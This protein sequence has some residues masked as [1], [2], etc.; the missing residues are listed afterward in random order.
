M[1]EKDRYSPRGT[2]D[3]REKVLLTKQQI[4]KEFFE[5]GSFVDLKVSDSESR[6]TL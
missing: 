2:L 3:M 6:S 1:N 5:G 4:K